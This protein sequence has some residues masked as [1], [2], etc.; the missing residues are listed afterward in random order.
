MTLDDARSLLA[1]LI[2]VPWADPRAV[3][4]R[5]RMDVEMLARYSAPPVRKTGDVDGALTVD[6]ANVIATVL[7]L[8]PDG[9][10]IAHGAVQRK[11]ADAKVADIEVKRVF[12][13]PAAR[14]RGAGRALMLELERIAR[15]TD[16]S[17]LILQTGDRQPEAVSLYESLGYTPIPVYEP[18]G[19]AIPFSLCF[20]KPLTL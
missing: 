19:E 12:V 5:R 8:D 14:G 10:A 3:E 11:R 9:T 15:E 1:T 13:D 17:R 7:V 2:T 20:A 4:L 6:P 16:A 18:Y